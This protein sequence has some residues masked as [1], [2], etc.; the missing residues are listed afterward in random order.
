MDAARNIWGAWDADSAG[1][2]GV[3]VWG[4]GGL[5]GDG[6]GLSASDALWSASDALFSRWGVLLSREDALLSRRDSQKV[7][8]AEAR[9]EREPP[10]L[11][12]K[13]DKPRRGAGRGGSRGSVAPPGLIALMF[14]SG[15]S[16]SFLGCF[17]S[18]TP[19]GAACGRLSSLRCDSPPATLGLSLRD[20]GPLVRGDEPFVRG[21]ETF[22]RGDEPL[23][24]KKEA[25]FRDNGRLVRGNGHSIFSNGTF[26]LVIQ[27]VW[28]MVVSLIPMVKIEGR[29]ALGMGCAVCKIVFSF[30]GINVANVENTL[31]WLGN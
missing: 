1:V 25:S 3:G 5:S 28:M 15:G 29:T 6:L 21:D 16:R 14:C 19:V 27:F 13:W 30:S 18:L 26:V 7:A 9:D 12:L 8:G 31:A 22:V 17:A 10:G 11:Y 4:W 2:G 23:A 24:R 20:N